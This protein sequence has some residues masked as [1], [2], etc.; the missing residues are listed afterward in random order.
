MTDTAD[1]TAKN[2]AAWDASAEHHGRGTYWDELVTGFAD[3]TYSCFDSTLTKA[4]EAAGVERG[5][6]HASWLQ[7]RA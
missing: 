6:S 5:E 7:Q 4:L 2:R 1:I 3:P